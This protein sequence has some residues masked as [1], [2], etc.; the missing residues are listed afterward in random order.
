MTFGQQHAIHSNSALGNCVHTTPWQELP[1]VALHGGVH[2]NF[3][4]PHNRSYR[5]CGR[6]FHRN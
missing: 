6:K 1:L 3:Q 4:A 5:G 2:Y